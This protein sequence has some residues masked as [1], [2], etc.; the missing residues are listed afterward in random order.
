MYKNQDLM[1]DKK[2]IIDPLTY[3]NFSYPISSSY[4]GWS[5]VT[6]QPCDMFI[7]SDTEFQIF[8]KENK[9]NHVYFKQ[10]GG[11]QFIS[12]ECSQNMC[13]LNGGLYTAGKFIILNYK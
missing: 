8:K 9:T 7:M 12:S 10:Y 3:D 4:I 5:L 13:P 6:D 11:I 1:I 2:S